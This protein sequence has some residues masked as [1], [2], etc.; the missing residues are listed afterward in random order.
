MNPTRQTVL[1]ELNARSD[2]ATG[3]TVPV[4]TL[5][6]ALDAHP[7]TVTP[8]IASLRDCGLV[9]TPTDDGVRITT[10]GEAFLSLDIDG[11]AVVSTVTESV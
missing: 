11:P 7:A 8:V 4:E 6:D 9:K 2:A 3:R 10:S 1:E 5:S